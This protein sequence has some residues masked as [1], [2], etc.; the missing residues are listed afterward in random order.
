MADG[1]PRPPLLEHGK[2]E[3]YRGFYKVNYCLKPIRTHDGIAVRFQQRQFDHITRES[4]NCDGVKD[5][6]SPE[7]AKR[8]GWI[9]LALEDPELILRAGWDK[10]T[11]R[12]DHKRRV[13]LMIDDFV[14][15]IRLKSSAEAEFVTCYVADSPRTRQKLKEGPRWINPYE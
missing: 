1:K 8:L 2:L 6:F 5:T 11:K 15:V 3:V 14:V 10:K 12:Y 4:S 7:R 13:T 9:K